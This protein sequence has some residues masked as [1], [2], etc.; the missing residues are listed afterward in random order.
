MKIDSIE[1]YSRDNAREHRTD[2]YEMTRDNTGRVIITPV[3]IFES[4]I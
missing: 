3:R 4:L 2:R 1:F